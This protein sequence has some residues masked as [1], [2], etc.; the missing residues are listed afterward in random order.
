MVDAPEEIDH[1]PPASSDPNQLYTHREY[2]G[3]IGESPAEKALREGMNDHSRALEQI[4]KGNMIE[5]Q[6]REATQYPL[7]K[8]GDGE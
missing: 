8:D 2:L 7:D 4:Q 1:L 3:R 6:N 5:K